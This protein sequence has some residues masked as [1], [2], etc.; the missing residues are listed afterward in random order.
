MFD[1]NLCPYCETQCDSCKEPCPKY[2]AYQAVQ[3]PQI[4]DKELSDLNIPK[5]SN[6][7]FTLLTIQKH[8][9]QRFHPIANISKDIT[10]HWVKEYCLCLEDEI[11]EIFDYISL[12]DKNAIKSDK[13]ELQKEVVDV[14]HF[15]LDVLIVSD[16]QYEDIQQVYVD[17]YGSFLG[18]LIEHVFIDHKV[19]LDNDVLMSKTIQLLLMNRE[20]LQQI[21]WKHW[22]KPSDKINYQ[23]L[24]KV[25]LELV[26]RFIQ[27]SAVVFDSVD[28][29]VDTYIHKNVENILRQKYG[30]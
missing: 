20:L 19:I 18:D 9:A 14:L 27:L 13:K 2:L 11:A 21:S 29:L 22:K 1:K 25:C 8:W 28:E 5:N 10:D 16:C 4:I 7:L 24:H 3:D 15:V 17:K 12:I 6:K 26:L 30:Y 23:K